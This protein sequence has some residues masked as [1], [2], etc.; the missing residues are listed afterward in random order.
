M[1]KTIAMWSGPRNISTAMMRAFENRSDTCVSDEPLY[2]HYLYHTGCPH[3]GASE[4]IESQSTDWSQL[5]TE[6]IQPPQSGHPIWYQKHMTHHLLAGRSVD[7]IGRLTNCF[8]IRDPEAVVS[9]Y[10]RTRDDATLE[11]LGYPQQ[12]ALFQR[13]WEETG[14]TPLVL[15]ARD[16]L[17]DPRAAL[18]H[19]CRHVGIIMSEEMLT[20]PAGPR[21]SDGVWGPHWYANVCQSTGF[22]PY[23][24]KVSA[25]HPRFAPIVAAARPM[26]AALARHRVRLSPS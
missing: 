11:D 17:M 13:I 10:T 18:A 2:A 16:V 21:D 15:D 20:W 12:L 24:P 3:P 7:W 4:V 1:T 8:L 22:Q 14:E 9:S 5:T 26:Y 6:L 25:Y 19:L 23:Q